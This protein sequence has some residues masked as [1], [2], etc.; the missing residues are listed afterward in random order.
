V[1]KFTAPKKSHKKEERKEKEGK[2]K[3]PQKENI[4]ACP[5][6]YGGHNKALA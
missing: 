6:P 4:I 3:K 1:Q 2:K 5:I